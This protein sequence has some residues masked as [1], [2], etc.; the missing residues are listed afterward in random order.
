MMN[1]ASFWLERDRPYLHKNPETTVDKYGFYHGMDN[2][3]DEFSTGER[4]DVKP[5]DEFTSALN[6]LRKKANAA[7][8]YED[9]YISWLTNGEAVNAQEFSDKFLVSANMAT[10]QEAKDTYLTSGSLSQK[11]ITIMRD[12]AIINDFLVE[13]LAVAMDAYKEILTE[14]AYAMLM[15]QLPALA[16]DDKVMNNI[17]AYVGTQLASALNGQK[18]GKN[19]T[20]SINGKSV[21]RNQNINELLK[22]TLR[23]K[24]K[25]RG[26]K[27]SI[28]A[29]GESIGRRLTQEIRSN[30]GA[31]LDAAIEK[32]VRKIDR[33]LDKYLTLEDFGGD[34]ERRKQTI[35]Y[36]RKRVREFLNSRKTLDSGVF[37]YDES[38]MVGDW[39]EFSLVASL[40]VQLAPDSIFSNSEEFVRS[41]ANMQVFQESYEIAHDRKITSRMKSG[42]DIS[43]AGFLGQ[44][45]SSK[46]DWAGIV[47]NASNYDLRSPR[48]LRDLLEEMAAAGVGLDQGKM[49]YSVVNKIWRGEQNDDRMKELASYLVDSAVEIY[50]RSDTAK[51]FLRAVN[52]T[53]GAKL[54]GAGAPLGG[55]SD[56]TVPQNHFWIA[57]GRLIGMSTF[58]FAAI[59]ALEDDKNF[60]GSKW[61]AGDL[62]SF[63]TLGDVSFNDRTMR[64]AKFKAGRGTPYWVGKDYG[65]GVLSVGRQYGSEVVNSIRIKELRASRRF[66]E[67]INLL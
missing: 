63:F 17:G 55:F 67:S 21:F 6:L 58:L 44:V 11:I 49:L 30:N 18:I 10:Y 43:I 15:E 26:G 25:A 9:D 14:D 65:E 12:P 34:K 53:E 29:K 19:L 16:T 46:A 56:Q 50:M 28:E 13:T 3:R 24:H 59:S 64:Y 37:F 33:R 45:K 40:T 47:G 48:N 41:L 62:G 7:K 52:R 57:G 38:N 35:A 1:R 39:G 42:S 51:S 23:A 8:R 66:I 20:L 54:P 31:L 60:T 36:L 61:Y 5:T 4:M 32:T 2:F 27:T 22:P